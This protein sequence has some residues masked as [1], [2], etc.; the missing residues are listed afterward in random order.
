MTALRTLWFIICEC[1]WLSCKWRRRRP[2][3]PV[4]SRKSWTYLVRAASTLA[5]TTS[6]LAR[7]KSET[8]SDGNRS[9]VYD[10]I[11][12]CLACLSLFHVAMASALC[13]LLCEM[14]VCMCVF[15]PSG[16]VCKLHSRDYRYSR[17]QK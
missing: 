13:S 15:P 12:S 7:G 17:Q 5:R 10:I 8:E 16:H 9:S 11:D 2:C 4:S 6:S 3:L 14:Y 1:D